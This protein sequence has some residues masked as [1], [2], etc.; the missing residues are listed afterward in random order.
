[1]IPATH[2]K[3]KKEL[4]TVLVDASIEL[5]SNYFEGVSLNINIDINTAVKNASVKYT[6]TN[7]IKL[8]L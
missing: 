1:M 5:L 6:E 3:T 8:A 7:K 4:E 2:F